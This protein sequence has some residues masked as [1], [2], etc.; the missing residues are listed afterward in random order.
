MNKKSVTGYIHIS[1]KDINE[2]QETDKEKLRAK[3][4]KDTEHFL[5]FKENKIEQIPRGAS[6]LTYGLNKKEAERLGKKEGDF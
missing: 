4:E 6:S 1:K 3:I 5:K 2:D